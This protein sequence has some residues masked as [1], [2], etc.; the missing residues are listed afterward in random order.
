MSPQRSAP[1]LTSRYQMATSASG[2][3]AHDQA[4][5]DG[6]ELLLL[7]GKPIRQSV[8]AYGPFVMNRR[9]EIEQAI[10]DYRRT[11]FGGWPWPKDDPV[12]APSEGR[13]AKHVDGRIE[14]PSP[15]S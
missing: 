8:A 10:Q 12:H 6:C 4:S 11:G 1:T 3:D 13:F 2:R 7:Q 9:D 14:R 5:A 15:R